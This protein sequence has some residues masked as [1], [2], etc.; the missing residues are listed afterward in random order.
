MSL[1]RRI[2]LWALTALT[3]VSCLAPSR[4]D[5]KT[6]VLLDELD[7]YLALREAYA[8][9]KQNQLDVYRNLLQATKDPVRRYELEMITAQEY[10]AFSFDSTQYY[11][12]SCQALAA[13]MGDQDRY[14][15]AA[16]MLGHLYD[17]AGNYLE[18]T[19]VLYNQIDTAS[20]SPELKAEY[21]WTLYD[22]S[23]D[24][25]GNSG[26]VERMSIPSAA[27]F[28]ER[29]YQLLPAESSRYRNILRDQLIEEGRLDAADSVSHLLLGSVKPEDRDFAIHAFFQSE[30]EEHKGN[31]PDRMLWLVKSAECDIV[32]AIRDYASLTMVAQ[33]I[34]PTDVDRSF[35]YLRIAQEDALIY[36]A[37]LRPWQISRFL[38]Q[39]EDA[40]QERQARATRAG[41]IWSILLAVLTLI[42]SFVSYFLVVRS[43]KLTKLRMELEESNKS[44]ALANVTLNDLNQQISKADKVKEKY[45]LNFLQG[46]SAQVTVIRAEDNRFRNL[47]KQGKADQLL[48]E[49][50]I[51]GRSEKARDEFYETFDTTF[52][53]LYPAFIEKFN[54]L[55]KE[56]A[57]EMAPDGRLTTAQR[58]FALIRLGVDD[59]KAIANMLDYSLSTIY[60]YKVTVKNAALGDREAFEEQVKAIGK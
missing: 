47:L 38:M 5:K 9:K 29:L 13:R 33:L 46:L 52:L 42:L 11:L 35:R 43:R 2:S 58:I 32:N 4:T 20:L 37:K 12:K 53:A 8:T 10:F 25:A 21:F 19:Q 30:I 44:L 36:N 3:V 56:D 59:S 39:I 55:L 51:S 49:L 27:S 16:I 18:A 54:A 1:R 26:M 45:I 60:N 50:S 40:Y 15:Q 28:R 14:N 41:Q 31:Q 24:M 48:K 7:G 34:L 22:Y 6:Q 57:R 23:K 17:K